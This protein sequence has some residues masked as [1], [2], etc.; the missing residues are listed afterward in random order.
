MKKIFICL[1]IFTGA[2]SVLRGPEKIEP[3]NFSVQLTRTQCFGKCPVYTAT[4]QADGKVQFM[5]L[6]NT[7][8]IGAAQDTLSRE[9]LD[10]LAAEINKANI[11]AF[12]DAYTRKSGNCPTYVT[13]QS[14]VTI[15]VE[16]GPKQ[17][18][19]EHYLGCREKKGPDITNYPQGLSQ[20]E[21][22]IGEIIGTDRWIK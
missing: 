3:T 21:D 2:C 5:G 1:A 17:K 18:A 19:I 10:Q 22:K 8:V 7:K 16:S 20:L 9:K 11:F 12:E 6:M 4:V 14:T 13:D 15:M